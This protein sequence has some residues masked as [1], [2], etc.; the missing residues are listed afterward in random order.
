MRL[1]R[2]PLCDDF[3]PLLFFAGALGTDRW[4]H[5]LFVGYVL[6]LRRP[7]LRGIA[8]SFLTRILLYWDGFGRRAGASL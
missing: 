1:L 2:G 4:L 6:G 5:P 7:P 3:A 8:V